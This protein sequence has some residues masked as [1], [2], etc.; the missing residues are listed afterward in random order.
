MVRPAAPIPR[1]TGPP[2]QKR[3]PGLNLNL[4][5]RQVFCIP[6]KIFVFGQNRQPE[7][8]AARRDQKICAAALNTVL[9]A[10]VE[11]FCRQ[12]VFQRRDILIGQ[13]SQTLPDAPKDLL[14]PQTL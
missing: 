10:G 7:R 13:G 4:L 9:A 14:S 2:K 6:G 12:L 3:E 5:E 8:H 1:R 11:K